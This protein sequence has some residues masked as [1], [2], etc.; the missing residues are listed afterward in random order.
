MLLENIRYGDVLS[1]IRGDEFIILLN[2][3]NHAQ[4]AAEIAKKIIAAFV[5]PFLIN[6]HL[7]DIKL[8]I[9]IAIYSLNRKE[10][11]HD[12]M[13]RADIALYKAKATGRNRY[14]VHDD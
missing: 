6:E 1:R 4:D 9:G 5:K 12:I 3:L 2:E 11:T 10:T 7:I 13:K 14:I 8:S